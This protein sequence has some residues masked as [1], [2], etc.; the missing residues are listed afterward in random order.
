MMEQETV[1][2]GVHH[3]QRMSSITSRGSVDSSPEAMR[4]NRKRSED[5][6]E[7]VSRE[8][9]KK[10][11][12]SS[13]NQSH[14][15]RKESYPFESSEDNTEPVIIHNPEKASPRTLIPQSHDPSIKSLLNQS[16]SSSSRRSV[17][18]Q[19][20]TTTT[21]ST[22]GGITSSSANIN[23]FQRELW[24]TL[25]QMQREVSKSS[26]VAAESIDT[27]KSNQQEMIHLLKS[28]ESGSGSSISR[29]RIQDRHEQRLMR[30]CNLLDVVVI[31]FTTILTHLIIGSL[32]PKFS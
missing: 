2:A 8:G 26:Q 22:S 20:G 16:S 1:G 9:S 25:R 7:G 6:S 15:E 30:S 4:R 24:S 23:S 32:I 28:I 29:N 18:K 19:I 12:A 3:H 21:S 27:L 10:K 31:V 17:N 11:S 13:S 14:Q 5:G